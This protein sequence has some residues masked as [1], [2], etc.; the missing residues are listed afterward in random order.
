MIKEGKKK[1]TRKIFLLT[2]TR[3][4]Y[5]AE[6]RAPGAGGSIGKHLKT[7]RTLW[8]SKARLPQRACGPSTDPEDRDYH[9]VL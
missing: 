9:N 7:M 5:R 2:Q 6:V 8:P 1:K 4:K 3:L